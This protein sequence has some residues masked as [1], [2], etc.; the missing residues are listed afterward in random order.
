MHLKHG[1]NFFNTRAILLIFKVTCV[2]VLIQIAQRYTEWKIGF[3]PMVNP[4]TRKFPL[5]RFTET[6]PSQKK[7]KVEVY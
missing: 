2:C 1:L 7:L 3:P 6:L 4:W 5:K